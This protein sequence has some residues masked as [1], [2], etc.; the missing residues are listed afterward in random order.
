M[1]INLIPKQVLTL[2]VI[3]FGIDVALLQGAFTKQIFANIVPIVANI[4]I[5]S[6]GIASLG[7]LYAAH[8][9]G[10]INFINN[11]GFSGSHLHKEDHSLTKVTKLEDL[12]KAH[13]I[14]LDALP[15]GFTGDIVEFCQDYHSA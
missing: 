11:G 9:C 13:D 2:G 15:K 12:I 7:V 6:T 3:G 5:T 10:I 14:C 8:Q 1:N 4:V